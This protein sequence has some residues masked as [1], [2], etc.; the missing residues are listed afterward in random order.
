MAEP[1]L[2]R[3]RANGLSFHA[4]LAGPTEGPLV[5]LLHGFPEFWY[6]WRHQIG[7]LAAAGFRVLAPDQRG[8]NLSDKPEGIA[9]YALDRLAED[10]AGLATAV[11]RK[12]FAV[13]GHD[14]GGVVAWHLARRFPDRVER[15]AVLNAPDP[16]TMDRFARSRPRQ[17]ARS[18]Y[19]AFFQLPAL[20]EAVLRAGGFAWLRQALRA[21]SR[22]GT[23]TDADLARYR[24]AW[25]QPGA[26][27]AMLNWYRA[28]R[29]RPRVGAA[30]PVEP[31]VRVIWGDG[32]RFLE[33]ELADLGAA[34]CA[35]GQALHL[36]EATH[37]I[38]HEEPERVNRLLIEFLRGAA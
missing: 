21:S 25:E 3:L 37:W 7:P 19:V 30:G 32:D 31:P 5:V 27:T 38:Q 22:P 28:L 34:G 4:A 36:P 8:Y 14:W 9:A 13:V 6:G 1:E 2:A 26:L 33:R 18:W 35:R 16:A 10:I 24:A 12:R 20:P 23:F 11:G 15:A 29:L 17:L